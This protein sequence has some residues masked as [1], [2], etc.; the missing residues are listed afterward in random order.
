MSLLNSK[1]IENMREKVEQFEGDVQ[2]ELEQF[3]ESNPEPRELKR[4]LAIR[5]LIQGV[6]VTIIQKIL[7]VSAAFVS[8]CK[9][10]FALE[11][12]QGLKLKHKG[13]KGYLN[14]RERTSLIEW[15]RSQNSMDLSKLE[16]YIEDNYGIKFKSKQS[17]YHLFKEAGMSW[18]KTQKF[19]PKRDQEKVE[20]R[21]QE[22]CDLLEENREDIETGKLVVYL[23]DEC[24]LLWGDVCGYGWGLTKE[25]LE[26]PMTNER[27]RQ[28]Y[29]GALNYQSKEFIV[30]DYKQGNSQNTVL[31]LKFLRKLNPGSR[32][33]IIWD[34]A[35][36]HKYKEMKEYLR[37]VNQ[38]LDPFKRP[39]HCEILAPNAPEQNPV[40]DIWLKAKNFLRKF[41]YKLRSFALVKW[42]FT[43]FVQREIFEFKKLHKYGVFQKKIEKINT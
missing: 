40:E 28:T 16:N 10:R 5:M 9:V 6:K 31:F 3:I 18:K 34:G 8:Q 20:A 1:N 15:L 41:W 11:G 43:F 12:I 23:I 14:Q 7:G 36:Y 21:H 13:S 29:Y 26:I 35:S 39:V 32:L 17:Y 2:E 27:D 37:E 30:R 4:A 42:L 19:N 24:H 22:I 33:L 38:D 25:R